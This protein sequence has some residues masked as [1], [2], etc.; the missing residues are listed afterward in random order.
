[1][2]DSDNS[3]E[4]SET[5]SHSSSSPTSPSIFF[6]SVAKGWRHSIGITV[7][8]KVFSWGKTNDVGQ[9]GRDENDD[10]KI[11]VRQPGN[12]PIPV[13]ARSAYC[14]QGCSSGSGHSGIIDENGQLWMAGCD[15]WQQLGLGSSNGGSSGYTWIGGKLWQERFVPSTAILDLMKKSSSST[16]SPS[17]T[18]STPTKTTI[19]DV[20][21]GGDHT[22]ILSSNQRDVYGFGKGGDGQLGLVGKPYV[23]APIKSKILSED[24]HRGEL[25]SAVGAVKNCSIT[26]DTTGSI[27]RTAGKCR[28][29]DKVLLHQA[30]QDCIERAKH[31]GLID[32][33]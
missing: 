4:S 5:A 22:L 11:P 8:G 21:L 6:V 7:D 13:I 27:R 14:S 33:R 24:P 19:R 1:M 3:C 30:L 31:D 25:L 12:V 32:Q 10:E 2:T 26:L 17:N 16:S 20:A 15:R 23:S 29:M 9:L 18:T 28:R